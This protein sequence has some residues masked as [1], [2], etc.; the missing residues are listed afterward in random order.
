[1]NIWREI[2]N[3]GAGFADED[4][5]AGVTRLLKRW[6]DLPAAERDAMRGNAR[7]CFERR[8]E[9]NQAVDSLLQVLEQR[10]GA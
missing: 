5:L 9:I 1:M 4:D 3:D 10:V 8:F 7:A 2:V 6:I